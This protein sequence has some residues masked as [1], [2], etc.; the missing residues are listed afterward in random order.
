MIAR[1]GTTAD[2]GRFPQGAGLL[3]FAMISARR[4]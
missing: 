3:L 2:E 4:R 1:R